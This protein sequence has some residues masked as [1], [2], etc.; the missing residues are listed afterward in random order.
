MKIDLRL[1]RKIEEDKR[2]VLSTREGM[3][4]I[5]MHDITVSKY[6]KEHKHIL[7]S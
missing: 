5:K 3:D 4:K 2:I 1:F 7:Y 6:W